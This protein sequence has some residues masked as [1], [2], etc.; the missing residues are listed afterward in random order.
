MRFEFAFE[1]KYLPALAA[2][3]VTP[4]TAR[5]D[6]DNEVLD[7]RFGPWHCRTPVG[8]ITCVQQTG[9]YS[10]I[11]AIGARGSLSDRGATFGTTTA[12]GVCVEFRKP[13]KILD[14][15]GMIL[16]PGLTL[17]VSDRDGLEEAV[18]KATGL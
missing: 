10:A 4:L 8:N 17:T 9:P 5:V 12:G 3:G 13:V 16:H 2:I 7:A 14:P 6:V 18:R 15:S 11:K 1:K